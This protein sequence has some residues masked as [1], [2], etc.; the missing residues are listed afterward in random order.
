MPI[1]LA[2]L[3]RSLEAGLKPVYLVAGAEPLL[4]QEARE[5]I[6]SAARNHGFE[7]RELMQAERGFEWDSGFG[8][9]IAEAWL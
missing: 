6:V 4:V 1:K 8:A 5:K 7:E 9:A 3:D 2:Q